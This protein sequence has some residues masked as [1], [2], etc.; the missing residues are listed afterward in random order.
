MSSSFASSFAPY[1]PPPDDS[2]YRSPPSSSSKAR[3]WFP[4]HSSSRGTEISYQSG[5][6]PTFNNS[7]S[8]HEDIQEDVQQNQ[9]ET[10]YGM[11]VD[12]LS[13]FAYILGPISALILLVLETHND[14][15]RFHGNIPRFLT[16]LPLSSLSTAYQSALS[17]T[18]LL[19][20]RI[21]ASLLGFPSW[22][23]SF[24]T[25]SL[26]LSALFMAIRAYFGASREGLARYHLPI[27]GPLAEKW[28][29]EE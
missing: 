12:V 19:L 13:A 23:R 4:V 14:Y 9:W 6:L 16:D 1:T 25:I 11:R 28:V 29:F 24:L 20:V 21:F 7:I 15:V 10:S 3:P 5:G 2:S 27:I 8:G 22:I 18:P 17:M 26:A